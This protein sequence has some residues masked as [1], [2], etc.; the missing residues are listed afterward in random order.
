MAEIQLNGKQFA[1]RCRRIF[2]VLNRPLMAIL[3]KTADVQEFNVN[4]ALFHYLLSYE[5]PETIL[6]IKEVPIAITSPKKALILQ[7]IEGLEVLVKNKDDSN[8]DE[9]LSTLRDT[10]GIVDHANM[11]GEFCET[12]LSK[13]A[14]EDV[15]SEVVGVLS[16]KESAEL[17]HMSR[18]G[19]VANYLLQKGI[20][21]IR[22]MNFSKEQLESY[23]NDPIRGVD[24]NYIEYSLDP[25]ES[26]NHLRLGIRYRGYCTE[27][28]RRFLT[29]LSEEYDIQRYA[30]SVVRPGERAPSV[31]AQVRDYCATQGYGHAVRMY[32]LGLLAEERSF[33]EDF[34]LRRNM[35]FC[36]NI[37]G[38]FCNTFVL[39]SPP[40]FITRKDCKEDYSD[41]RMRFRN[42]SGD[43]ALITK[44]KEHQKELLDAL[45]EDQARHYKN[46]SVGAAEEQDEEDKVMRYARESDV[47]RS[48]DV[49]LDWENMYVLV[50]VLSYSVPFHIST[51]KNVSMV[52][53]NDWPRLRL[54]F[55]ESK[56]LLGSEEDADGQKFDSTIRSISVKAGNCEELLAQINEMKKEFNKPKVCTK[57][58]GV[59]R[60]KFKKYALTDLYMR[61]DNKMNSKK[62]LGNLELHEN[63]FRYN[64]V[65]VLFSNI[66][67]IFYSAGDFENR[68]LLHLNLK[69][70]IMLSKMTQ[71][72]QFFR[73][74]AFV[75][76]DTNKREDERIDFIQQQE[77]EAEISR[78]NTEFAFFVEQIEHETKLKVQTPD[79][80]FLG[81]HS[82]EAVH[83]SVTNECLV[84]IAEHPF[85]VLNFDEVEIVNFERV[86]F[87][88]K[89][90]D[91]VFVFRD[92]KR[93]VVTISSIE[94]TRLGFLK[95]L[96]D[97]HNIVFMET[98]VNINWAHLIPTIMEDPL[99][100]Y[101]SGG[102]TELLREEEEEESEATGGT[103]TSE[104][105]ATTVETTTTS[106]D[107]SSSEDHSDDDESDSC[108]ES[109]S[110]SSSEDRR[111]TKKA[112]R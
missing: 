24:P 11:K 33:E 26:L 37:S 62:V 71:N 112:R 29:D 70:P 41:T 78:I 93:P 45:I 102:W 53:A 13:V 49:F 98:K 67:N 109:D 85:F 87:V 25:E 17:E 69:E 106:D 104:T 44:I 35:C 77:E 72:V 73:K 111:R 15:T 80:G 65:V 36:L 30:L 101:E 90:F 20:D 47:P 68:A 10:Y 91:C 40:T 63:G 50:P 18:C 86:T 4:S 16:V 107:I 51:I 60:E 55:K 14:H 105:T 83:V 61:T 94:T 34:E 32:T 110:E 21:L 58:Q 48:K 42:K 3:G 76:H 96:L 89:T 8:L 54:N 108:M 82:K 103:S 57:E 75:Y 39:D 97:S 43:V 64:D 28:A 5:F 88:T 81:V 22:D 66:K 74:F 31:L 23:M 12:V 19:T 99:S 1:D 52:G 38:E 46:Q 7:Q 9:I 56:E 100:F 27:I 59:L 2:E 6:I 92:K 95:E 84:S 79:K